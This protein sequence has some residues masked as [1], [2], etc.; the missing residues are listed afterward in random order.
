M[1]KILN[2]FLITTLSGLATLIGIIPCYFKADKNY[3]IHFS[4]ALSSG[5]M[6]CI[7]LISLIPES[8]K[9]LNNCLL[10]I[11]FTLT[12]FIFT[13]L[14]DKIFNNQ[15]KNKLY[16]L[17]LISTFAII[18]HNIPEGITTF[19]SYNI[20]QK[21]GLKLALAIALH[22]IPEG[23]SIAVPIYYSTKNI[24]KAFKY[25]FIAGFSELLGAIITH[26]FLVDII[27]NNHIGVILSLTAGIMLEISL[28]ELLPT[29]IKYKKN[30]LNLIIFVL[31][32]L[33]MFICNCLL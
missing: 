9:Y 29:A 15:N 11:V 19:I 8:I 14:I 18:L 5:V 28:L 6:F 31:G 10:V 23:I 22:N 30:K 32:F 24:F 21:L 12:G 33:I 2:S 27:T 7:S 17:G 13:I 1:N 20:N 26:L 25:T 4:L 16:R 3:I